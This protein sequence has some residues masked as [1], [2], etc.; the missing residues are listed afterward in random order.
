MLWAL[1]GLH[2]FPG[3]G[4]GHGRSAIHQFAD[5]F[6]DF[7]RGRFFEQIRRGPG[8]EALENAVGIL[9]HGQ[10]HQ[11]KFGAA[12]LEAAHAL[13]AAHPGQA[14][15]HEHHVRLLERQFL[16][17]LLRRTVRAQ[18]TE[19]WRPVQNSF[20][21]LARACVVFNNGNL[22]AHSVGWRRS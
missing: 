20:Q 7:R 16:Q 8:F 14:Q 13:D 21:R 19:T 5:A 22:D 9:M 15:V 18:A 12:F 10:D 2:N 6:D 17:G 1:K 11:E 3:D 4:G